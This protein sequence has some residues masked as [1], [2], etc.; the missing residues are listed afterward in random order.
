MLALLL[1]VIVFVVVLGILL[2][3]VRARPAG[4]DA[5]SFDQAVGPGFWERP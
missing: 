2:P 5:G 1:A 3:L 4:P